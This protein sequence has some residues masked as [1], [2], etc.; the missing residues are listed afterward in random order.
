MSQD[1]PKARSEIEWYRSQIDRLTT[2]SE[3]LSAA[4]LQINSSLIELCARLVNNA[5]SNDAQ[6]LLSLLPLITREEKDD[7]QVIAQLQKIAESLRKEP[8]KKPD[9]K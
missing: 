5:R 4:L 6:M 7:P 8:E 9:A 1:D 2:H 3:A